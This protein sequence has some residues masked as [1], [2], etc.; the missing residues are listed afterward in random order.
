MSEKPPTSA[1]AEILERIRD[2]RDYAVEYWK[3]MREKQAD[4]VAF[5]AI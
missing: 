5:R 4:D 1:D 3:D 2:R